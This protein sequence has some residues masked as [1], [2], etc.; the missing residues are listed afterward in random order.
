MRNI[1]FGMINWETSYLW[2]HW[3]FREA[4]DGKSNGAAARRE[5]KVQFWYKQK[6]SM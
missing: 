4:F 6:L 3:R 2:G 1:V 5:R